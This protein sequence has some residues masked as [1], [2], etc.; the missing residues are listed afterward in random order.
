MAMDKT[1]AE[2]VTRLERLNKRLCAIL[3][4][5]CGLGV[6]IVVAAAASTGGSDP[7]SLK[8]SDTIEAK[9]IILRDDSG[10]QRMVFQ[11][12]P[13]GSTTF[14]VLD[15]SGKTRLTLNAAAGGDTAFSMIRGDDKPVLSLVE[16]ADGGTM[17]L[18]GDDQ[19]GLLLGTD[20]RGSGF[21][22]VRN[23]GKMDIQKLR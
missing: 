5:V 4:V 2:R 16:K 10:R 19:S 6:V 14:R 9:R 12:S 7:S 1:L 20:P 3:A 21:L 18:M 22:G 15:G 13:K 17:M 8:S 23:A 11:V